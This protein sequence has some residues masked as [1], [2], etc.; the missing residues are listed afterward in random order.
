MTDEPPAV[1]AQ[2]YRR[3]LLS[4]HFP[5]PD[6]SRPDDVWEVVEWDGSAWQ[7]IGHITQAELDEQRDA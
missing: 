1:G 7:S 4:P 5:S 2:R 6:T 3:R